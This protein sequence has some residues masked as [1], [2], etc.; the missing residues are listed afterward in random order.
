MI[1][2]LPA[3][4]LLSCSLAAQAQW[5]QKPVKVIVPFA[6][7]GASD[8]MPLPSLPRYGGRSVYMSDLA[9]RVEKEAAWP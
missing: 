9:E 1:R 8:L 3:L 5:P 7:G 4:F 6:P 2:P